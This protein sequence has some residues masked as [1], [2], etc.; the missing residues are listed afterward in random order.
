MKLKAAIWDG[1]KTKVLGV[2]DFTN[3]KEL[4]NFMQELHVVDSKAS[5]RIMEV[6]K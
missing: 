4:Q 6:A 5:Y 3:T 2:M 1:T